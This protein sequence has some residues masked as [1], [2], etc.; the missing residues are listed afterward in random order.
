MNLFAGN[1]LAERGMDLVYIPL[2]IQNGVKKVQLQQE[3]M[4]E[5]IE[6]WQKAIIM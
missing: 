5:D 2:L 1:R 4:A 3:E 6:K